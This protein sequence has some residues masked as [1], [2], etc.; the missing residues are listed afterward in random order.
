MPYF[1]KHFS[2]EPVTLCREESR[3][4][5]PV[6]Y[7]VRLAGFHIRPDFDVL[8]GSVAGQFV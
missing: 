3:I 2:P 7:T 1:G 6:V 4:G 8:R 5:F